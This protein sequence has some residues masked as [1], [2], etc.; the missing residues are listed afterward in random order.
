MTIGA[1]D[2]DLFQF[3]DVSFMALRSYSDPSAIKSAPWEHLLLKMKR[4]F[5]R[6][7]EPPFADR[8]FRPT[9]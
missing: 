4:R 9:A 2:P 5:Y 8:E 1:R 6:D 3:E 7:A